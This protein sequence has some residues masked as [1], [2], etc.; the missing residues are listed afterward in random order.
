MDTKLL[1]SVYKYVLSQT[2]LSTIIN[3]I[4]NIGTDRPEQTV[5]PEQM[6]ENA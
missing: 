2:K 5:D 1:V 4:I 3:L 6:P